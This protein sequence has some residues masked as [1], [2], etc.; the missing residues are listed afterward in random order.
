MRRMLVTS[1]L[2]ALL[3]V[4]SA[5]AAPEREALRVGPVVAAAGQQASGYLVVPDG[6]DPGTKIPVSVFN[7]AKPGP[8]LALIAGTHGYEYT[9]IV[10]LQRLRAAARPGDGSRAP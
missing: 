3:A 5:S 8:V 10:A 7:G 9:S 1:L 6:V 4:S 2:V